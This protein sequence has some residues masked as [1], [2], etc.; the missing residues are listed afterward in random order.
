MVVLIPMNAWQVL[1]DK[2]EFLTISKLVGIMVIFSVLL[3][4]INRQEILSRIK[5]N[6][7]YP[8]AL[9]FLIS[10]ISTFYSDFPLVCIDNLRKMI[11]A[12]LFLALTIFFIREKQLK[13][14]LPILLIASTSFSAFI[15]IAGKILS[16]E[17]LVI[18]M[19]LSVS[20]ER[21]IGTANDPN[22]FAAMILISFPL[23]AHFFFHNTSTRIRILLAALFIHNCYAIILTYSRGV[24]LALC[25]TL[26]IILLENIKRIKLRYLG[27]LIVAAVIMGSI[28]IPKIPEMIIWERMQTLLTPQAD[29]SLTR[30]ASY[31]QVA[32]EA[33][34]YDPVIGSG[35]GSFPQIY[36]N[37]IYATALATKASGFVR[38]AHNTY[39]EIVVGTGFLGLGLFLYTLFI[40]IKNFFN[41]QKH[42]KTLE[43]YSEASYVRALAY[44]FIS[45]L[46]SFMFL[47]AVYRKYLWLFLGLSA[48]V[49]YIY[50]NGEEPSEEGP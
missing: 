39:L 2:Y 15:A 6:L 12:F 7:W 16:I 49:A 43:K 28:V 17:T 29:T 18:S 22:F 13:K 31:I 14:T 5:T 45:L 36:M 24:T 37:S 35:P 21:A 47:S 11:T 10:I 26:I 38:A 19:D 46:F 30:R 27:F 50:K 9:F 33:V 32:K 20:A 4:I 23:I 3:K 34:V 40:G 8:L 1:I 42:L 41:T 25:F 48:V 44:S